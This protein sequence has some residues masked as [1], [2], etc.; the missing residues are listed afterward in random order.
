MEEQHMD[1]MIPV[2]RTTISHAVT[3]WIQTLKKFD[4]KLNQQHEIP[5]YYGRYVVAK[6]I[7]DVAT[8][9]ID[10]TEMIRGQMSVNADKIQ[11]NVKA[12]MDKISALVQTFDAKVESDIKSKTGGKP[13]TKGATQAQPQ[14]VSA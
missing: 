5:D 13:Y 2:I 14:S 8:P 3:K 12:I 11:V 4:I 9:A 10:Y 1:N 7:T 6:F